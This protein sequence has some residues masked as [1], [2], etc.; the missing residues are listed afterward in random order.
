MEYEYSFEVKELE[1]Y[2]KF[3]EENGYVFKEKTSQIRTIYRKNDKTMARITIKNGE[4]MLLDFK[5]D[6]L[7]DDV[8]IERRETPSIQFTN[9]D[10]A[11]KILSFL[12]YEKDNSLSRT[13]YVY[14]KGN[15]I[16][17]LDH[18]LEPD[19]TYVVA[20]EGDKA[21]VDKVYE[22][23]KLLEDNE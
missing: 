18:Y 2:I 22:T 13:R 10:D 12:H 7:S 17:E 5:D 16:F 15:V 8:L 3:C 20:I 9:I 21:E 19:E 4:K 6:I 1:K 11:N 14:E 23:V